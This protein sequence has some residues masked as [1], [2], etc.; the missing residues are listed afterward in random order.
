MEG[1]THTAADT[2]A[3]WTPSSVPG[4]VLWLDGHA[5]LGVT[6]GG[7]DAGDGGPALQWLDQSGHDNNA[8]GY[9]SPA[10]HPTALGGQPAVH[11]GGTDYLLVQDSASLD[12][13]TG[14]FVLAIVVQHTTSTDAG[15]PYGTL[16]SKQIYDTAPF[17]GVGLFANTPTRTSA[18]LEQL[19]EFASTEVTSGGT[20]YNNGSPFIVVVHRSVTLPDGGV[21][22]GDGGDAAGPTGTMNMLIDALDAGF[23]TG[24]GYAANVNS[25]G[26]PA[27]IGGTQYGQNLTGDIAE[28]IAIQG[29]VSDANLQNLQNYLMGKYGL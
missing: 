1:G 21:D 5:G 26:Y 20:G 2:G 23:A 17:T 4:L 10:V 25:T 7:V 3:L 27:R 29:T 16:Y 11:F 14:D 22:A 28:V 8:I 15:T 18:I 12:W 19:N 9:G 13:G 24:A 6:D